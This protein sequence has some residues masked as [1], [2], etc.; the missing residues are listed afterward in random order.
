MDI[1]RFEPGR[2]EKTR[3]YTK[4]AVHETTRFQQIARSSS[5]SSD[6]NS[7]DVYGAQITATKESVHSFSG[8]ESQA[9]NTRRIDK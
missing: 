6:G 8:I 3:K 1:C 2:K 7:L 5:G 9:C 4:Y